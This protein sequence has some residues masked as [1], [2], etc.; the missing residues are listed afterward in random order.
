MTTE[1]MKQH[2]KPSL[3][4]KYEQEMI[5]LRG[6]TSSSGHIVDNIKKL[7]EE[8]EKAETEEERRARILAEDLEEDR[9]FQEQLK[10]EREAKHK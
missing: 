8:L 1:W 10:Q 3:V 4:A 9:S 2:V 6:E 7:N 5:K